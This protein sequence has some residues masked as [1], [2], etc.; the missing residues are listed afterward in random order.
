MP[1]IAGDFNLPTVEWST[2]H[3]NE[4]LE[5]VMTDLFVEDFEHIIDFP[6]RGNNILDLLFLRADIVVLNKQKFHVR[7]LKTDHSAVCVSVS[8]N[9]PITGVFPENKPCYSFCKADYASIRQ[10]MI[11]QPFRPECWSNPNALVDEW[12]N[13]IRRVVQ[14]FVPRRTKHR[15]NL[16]PW[17]TPGTCHLIKKLATKRKFLPEGNGKLLQL[18]AQVDNAL[19]LDRSDYEDQLSNRRSQNLLQ[20]L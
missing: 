2:C 18:V 10:S 1:I 5:S 16:P 6:T 20:T 12:E 3:S 8:L 15:A 7:Q 19:Q 14:K 11:S 4:P 13:W 9:K 17:V